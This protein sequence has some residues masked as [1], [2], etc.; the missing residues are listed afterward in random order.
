[1][2]AAG[3]THCADARHTWRGGR[4]GRSGLI[5]KEDHQFAR[6]EVVAGHPG[7]EVHDA[8]TLQ[9]RLQHAVLVVG[10]VAAAYRQGLVAVHTRIAP[11]EARC[12]RRGHRDA[13]VVHQRLGRAWPAQIDLDVW[14]AVRKAC[15]RGD[16]VAAAEDGGRR[17]RRQAARLGIAFLRGL[18]GASSRGLRWNSL[19]PS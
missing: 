3:Q 14:V 7:G 10:A 8:Q 16:D 2:A 9:C 4:G 15:Q 18:L 5:G 17:H 1:M 11:H 12:R 19:A 6:A 13:V